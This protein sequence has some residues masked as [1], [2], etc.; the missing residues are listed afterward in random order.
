M[1]TQ[2]FGLPRRQATQSLQFKYG[3]AV[4]R[5]KAFVVC[6]DLDNLNAQFVAQCARVGEKRLASAIGVQ[7]GAANTDTMHAHQRFTRRD[8]LRLVGFGQSKTFRLL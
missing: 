1:L 2:Q 6:T 5:G 8:A 3:A 4:A 7:V